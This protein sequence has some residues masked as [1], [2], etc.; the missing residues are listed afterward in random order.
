MAEPYRSGKNT[1]SLR[2]RKGGEDYLISGQPSAR[3]AKQAERDYLNGLE[4]KGKPLGL[5]PHA[6]T[7]AQAMSDWGL[8][9]LPFLKSAPQLQRRINRYVRLADLPELVLEPAPDDGADGDDP[10]V[11]KPGRRK[12]SKARRRYFVVRVQE[13][14]E[15]DGERR[16]VNSLK[17]HRAKLAKKTASSDRLRRRLANMRVADI[18]R[19]EVQQLIDAMRTE[20]AGV[21]TLQQEQALLRAFF[22]DAEEKWNWSAPARNPATALDMPAA[23]NARDRVMTDDEERRL[24]SALSTAR[25]RQATLVI[26]MLVETAMRCGEPLEHASWG[27]VDWNRCVL[28]LDDGKAGAREVP[29]SPRAVEL[30]HELHGVGPR[31]PAEPI[32][33]L[34]YPALTKVWTRACERAQ[35]YDLVLHDLRHTAATRLAL[36][37]GNPFLVKK[38]T[39]HKT[40]SQLARYVNISADDVVKVLKDLDTSSEENVAGEAA[41]V[42]SDVAARSDDAC[43]QPDGNSGLS[44][45]RLGENVVE[46]DFGARQR[47]DS[48]PV[49]PVASMPSHSDDGS[50]PRPRK[51]M[52]GLIESSNPWP[53]RS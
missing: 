50:T 1:W 23:D 26:R 6:T 5:G 41:R 29:L 19:H 43:T 14:H 35:I 20:E 21:G 37:T 30:L 13:E 17:G 32:V 15:R 4:A 34:S 49:D 25:N 39:G 10:A 11:S 16:I 38:Q 24:L 33:R 31:H 42:P 53:S 27:D 8:Q 44:A 51:Q 45:R 7:L 48:V 18:T 2:S 47:I 12:R 52:H 46:V 40:W 28:R 3:A 9:R 22:Y 36:R